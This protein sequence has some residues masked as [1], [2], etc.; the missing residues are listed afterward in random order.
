MLRRVTFLLLKAG[1]E[2]TMLPPNWP[3]ILTQDYM[4]TQLK[5][6]YRI[7]AK[8]DSLGIELSR[9]ARLF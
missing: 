8:V 4:S 1:A 2:K 5:V 3:P 9:L 7:N 6:T